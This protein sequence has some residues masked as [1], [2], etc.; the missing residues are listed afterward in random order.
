MSEPDMLVPFA[1]AILRLRSTATKGFVAA[2]LTKKPL[3]L[4]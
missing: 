3:V 4:V 1:T 2:L